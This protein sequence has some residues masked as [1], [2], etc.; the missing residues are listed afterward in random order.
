VE[1]CTLWDARV[2]PAAQRPGDYESWFWMWGCAA[3]DDEQKN[4]FLTADRYSA[5]EVAVLA[6]LDDFRERRANH[7]KKRSACDMP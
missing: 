4:A 7:R 2:F 6:E 3:P 5:A 1:E